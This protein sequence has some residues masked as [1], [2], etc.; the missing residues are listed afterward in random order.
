MKYVYP[1]I[2]HPE[3]EGG[4]SIWFPD[5]PSGATQGEDWLDGIEYAEDCLALILYMMEKDGKQIPPATEPN[6]VKTEGGEFVTLI[7]A[8]TE[9][10]YKW[11]AEQAARKEARRAARVAKKKPELAPVS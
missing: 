1:A 6:A 4:Y 11:F 7:A 3:D 8:D 10:Y 2:F 5:L 9:F